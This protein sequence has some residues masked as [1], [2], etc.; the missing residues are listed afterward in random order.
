MRKR[1]KNRKGNIRERPPNKY[2]HIIREG[3]W[4]EF[5]AHYLSDNF[6]VI[7]MLMC[8]VQYFSL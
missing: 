3:V 2:T 4:R 5:I 8:K 1:I 6:Q 7:L